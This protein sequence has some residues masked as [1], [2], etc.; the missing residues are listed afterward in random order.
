MLIGRTEERLNCEKVIQINGT[1]TINKQSF[2]STKEVNF[3]VKLI[4]LFASRITQ[5]LNCS[6]SN[7]HLRLAQQA[8]SHVKVSNFTA[9]INML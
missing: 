6:S 9:E 5:L 2:A 1:R 4:G 7:G 8:S 3:S